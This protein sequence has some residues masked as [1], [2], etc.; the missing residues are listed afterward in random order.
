MPR[1]PTNF[2][3]ATRICPQSSEPKP[4]TPGF[5]GSTDSSSTSASGDVKSID[6]EK[7]LAQEGLDMGWVE[8][9][10]RPEVLDSDVEVAIAEPGLAA[11]DERFGRGRFVLSLLFG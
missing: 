5:L 4:S 10:G 2:G 7:S 9:N 3:N 1:M 8:A 11:I 6:P